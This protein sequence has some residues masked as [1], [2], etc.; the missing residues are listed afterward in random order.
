MINV[1]IQY[2][3]GE[4]ICFH[5]AIQ[6]PREFERECLSVLLSVRVY[7][8]PGL[9][10]DFSVFNQRGGQPNWDS[11]SFDG[12]K[13]TRRAGKR[14]RYGDAGRL[15][16]ASLTDRIPTGISRPCQCLLTADIDRCPQ[17]AS[18]CTSVQRK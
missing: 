5:D 7:R 4:S 6:N 17:P 11:V 1:V 18:D 9:C 16:V 15:Y 13:H 14:R 10:V 8:R 2:R 3:H 12:S